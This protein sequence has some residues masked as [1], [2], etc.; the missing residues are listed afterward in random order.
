MVTL[1]GNGITNHIEM[2]GKITGTNEVDTDTMI[3]KLNTTM[4]K[5]TTM[6]DKLTGTNKVDTDTMIHKLNTTTLKQTTM[7]AMIREEGTG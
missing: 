3:H 2:V 6:V 7:E 5:Q 1:A 4:L